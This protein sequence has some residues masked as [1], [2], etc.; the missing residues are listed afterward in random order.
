VNAEIAYLPGKSGH[1]DKEGLIRWI[2]AFKEKPAMVF[3]NHGEDAVVK[4]YAACL[5]DEYGFTVTAPYSGAVYDLIRNCYVETP[6]GVPVSREKAKQSRA[7]D[8][9]AA[10]LAA[11]ERLL[12]VIRACK[13]I[14]N[15][16]LSKFTGQVNSLADKWRSWTEK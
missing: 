7:G 3:V 9:F 4:S 1:A 10:L 15:K 5:Q 13:G 6:E 16:E 14:P 11:G 12:A 8:A 2:T